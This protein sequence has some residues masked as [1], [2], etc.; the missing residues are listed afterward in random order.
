[1]NPRSWR[2]SSLRLTQALL[3]NA[4]LTTWEEYDYAPAL[5]PELVFHGYAVLYV[6]ERYGTTL[7]WEMVPE[8]RTESNTVGS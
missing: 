2:K 5:G 8:E 6:Q 4:V 1:V 3:W 7:G